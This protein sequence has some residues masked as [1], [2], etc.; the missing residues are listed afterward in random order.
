MVEARDW[1]KVATVYELHAYGAACV[2]FM[3]AEDR[4][5]FAASITGAVASSAEGGR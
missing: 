3:R 1:A 5:S 4:A 2:E